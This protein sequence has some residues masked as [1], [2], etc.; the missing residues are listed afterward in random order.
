[1]RS[2]E[3]FEPLGALLG[4]TFSKTLSIFCTN[5]STVFVTPVTIS[6]GVPLFPMK[7]NDGNGTSLSISIQRIQTKKQWNNQISSNWM[8]LTDLSKLH[9]GF[10]VT[11]NLDS[12]KMF[13]FKFVANCIIVHERCELFGKIIRSCNKQ[14]YM[15]LE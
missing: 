7:N 13:A 6:S 10:T 3:A 12:N 15:F 14:N 2:A 9:I 11:L 4:L 5:S 8:E 1:M